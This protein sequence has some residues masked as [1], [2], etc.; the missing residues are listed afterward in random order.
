MAIC[1]EFYFPSSDGSSRIHAAEWTPESGE[2]IGVLQ[3][4]HGRGG[5]RHALRAVCRIYDRARLCRRGERP[6]R[7]RPFRR[8]G[9][10]HAL[11]QARATAGNMLWTTCTPYAAARR[12]NIPMFPIFSWATRWL[13]PDAHLSHP[14]SRHRR[15]RHHHG[16]GASVPRNRR[17]GA[18][19]PRPRASA[20]ASRRTLRAWRRWLSVLTTR[21]S[22]PTARRSTGSARAT[23]MLTPTLPTPSAVRRRARPLLRDARRHPLH[24]HAEKHRVDEPQHAHSL[25]LRRQGPCR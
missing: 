4:A 13:V 12:K 18:P 11:F 14:L 16:H 22:R 19:S 25:H 21:R 5:I 2:I 3:I 8:E 23:T 17:G 9:R 15:R 24:Q 10:R 1:R 6:P 7:P 20:T